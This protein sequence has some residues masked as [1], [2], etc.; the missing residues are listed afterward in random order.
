MNK[1][2]KRQ[3]IGTRYIELLGNFMTDVKFALKTFEDERDDLMKKSDKLVPK[4]KK[5]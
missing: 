5:K 1:E 4:K 3:E 2:E